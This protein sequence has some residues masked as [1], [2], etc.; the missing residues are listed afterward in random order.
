MRSSPCWKGESLRRRRCWS[1][2]G[3]WHQRRVRGGNG[4][5]RWWRWACRWGWCGG[6][7]TGGA[8]G[9]PRRLR[10]EGEPINDT[11][12][13][14]ASR[15]WG[16]GF[17]VWG[18]VFRVWGFGFGVGVGREGGSRGCRAARGFPRG[19]EKRHPGAGALPGEHTRPRVSLAA[20]P[21][22]ASGPAHQ[23]WTFR[24]ISCVPRV[25]REGAKNGTRG[26]VRSPFRGKGVEHE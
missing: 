9:R 25:F 5:W 8:Q 16:L 18:V 7:F 10:N 22:P 6:G 1:P 14:M 17:R 12:R 21:Q 23:P 11:G 24:T 15:V 26:R 4:C 3:N 20:P 2:L 19:R 13:G